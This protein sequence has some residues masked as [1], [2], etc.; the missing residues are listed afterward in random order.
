MHKEILKDLLGLKV[1]IQNKK[2]NSGKLTIEYKNLRSIRT[3]I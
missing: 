3:Y 2:N 1:T